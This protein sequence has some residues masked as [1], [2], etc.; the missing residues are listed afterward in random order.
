M[1]QI[2]HGFLD[3]PSERYFLSTGYNVLC[4]PRYQHLSGTKA[5]NIMEKLPEFIANHLFLVS[6]LVAITSLLLWNIFSGAIGAT[7]IAPT[8]VTRLINHEN[9]KV[10]D[11][12]RSEEFEK[13]HIINSVNLAASTLEG[14]EK[15]L[16]KYKDKTVVLYCDHGQESVRVARS[17]KMK[18]F[19]KLYCLKGGIAAW[20]NANLPLTKNT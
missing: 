10:L 9:A 1:T 7:Q 2:W 8:E 17:L 6:L 16:G 4:T 5:K 3:F 14:S 18:G 13:G 19:E 20:Q 11:L 15:E 12:R